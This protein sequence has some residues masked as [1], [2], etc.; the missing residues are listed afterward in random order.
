ML[1]AR[2]RQLEQKEEDILTARERI[3]HNRIKNK[4]RFDKDHGRRKE[5][6]KVR[7][8]VLL[9]NTVL[10]KQWSRKLDNRWLGPYLIREARLDLGTY[11]LSELNGT[12]LNGV[13][14]GHRLKKFFQ[15]DGIEPDKNDAE[16]EQSEPS[17]QQEIEEIEDEEDGDILG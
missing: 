2:A 7:D 11:L 5:V 3:R 14:A 10:D 17:E 16:S 15:R 1:V 13:Y 9:Y 12:E 4:A 8:L 6:L